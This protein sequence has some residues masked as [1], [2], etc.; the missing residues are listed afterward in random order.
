MPFGFGV[1]ASALGSGLTNAQ[2][3]IT[4]GATG[5]L[6]SIPGGFVYTDARSQPKI[7]EAGITV[8][9]IVAWRAWRVFQGFLLS[10]YADK[11]WSPDE[12]MDGDVDKGYGVH[13]WRSSHDAL[14][15]GMNNVPGM[16]VGRVALWGTVVEHERGYRAQYAKPLSF[17]YIVGGGDPKAHDMILAMLR[18]QYKTETL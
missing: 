17:D 2:Q 10:V 4:L 16:V 9:E 13:A 5:A 6:Y 14:H 8:G 7:E 12:P 1:A 18:T 11:A 3:G 15:Y